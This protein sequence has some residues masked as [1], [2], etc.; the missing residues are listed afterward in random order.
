MS[1]ISEALKKVA[2]ERGKEQEWL[3]K[4]FKSTP[5]KTDFSK[6]EILEKKWMGEKKQKNF[7][8]K[9]KYYILFF[10]LGLIALGTAVFRDLE[11]RKYQISTADSKVFSLKPLT[12]SLSKEKTFSSFKERDSS[13][14][15]KQVSD[16]GEFPLIELTGIMMENPPRALVNGQFVMVG[17]KVNGVKILKIYS[18]HVVFRFQKK[19]FKKFIF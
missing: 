7:L 4:E 16:G 2:Q 13:G 6:K 11:N 14:S 9:K 18:D 8:S 10:V 1:V 17:D 12:S 3:P 15:S 19:N 5:L